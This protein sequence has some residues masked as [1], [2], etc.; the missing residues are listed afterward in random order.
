MWKYIGGWLC[1]P[2]CLLLLPI[3]E[4]M[5]ILHFFIYIITGEESLWLRDAIEKNEEE[6]EKEEDVQREIENFLLEFP[7]EERHVIR[8]LCLE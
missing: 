5:A 4:I 3:G 2:S 1:Q 8:K 6:K 7:E